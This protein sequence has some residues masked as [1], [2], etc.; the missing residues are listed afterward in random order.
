VQQ[1]A[2]AREEVLAEE[3]GV[4]SAVD[5][6]VADLSEDEFLIALPALRQAF[7]M[8]PPRERGLIAERLVSARGGGDARGLTRKLAVDPV[9]MAAAMALE[10]RV[11]AALA[12]EDLVFGGES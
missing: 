10:A 4:V 5:E 6:L 11:E 12:R 1:I 2:V 7:A 3:Q 8:F 9:V